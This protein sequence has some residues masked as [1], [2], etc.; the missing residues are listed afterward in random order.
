MVDLT[1]DDDLLESTVS[2]LN[3]SRIFA[4]ARVSAV[5]QLTEKPT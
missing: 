3:M 1:G 4:Y 2:A 5:A